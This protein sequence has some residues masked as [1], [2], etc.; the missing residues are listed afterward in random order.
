[1]INGILVI[2]HYLRSN[3]F[4]DLYN[5]FKTSA[6]NNNINLSVKTNREILLDI[7]SSTSLAEN[8]LYTTDTLSINDALL[9][10][11][12]S[13]KHIITEQ[14]SNDRD[15]IFNNNYN[16]KDNINN[17]ISF[18]LF[19]DKDVLL[20]R[21]LESKGY[22]VFN[23]SEA[24]RICDDK[25]LTHIELSNSNIPMPRTIVSPFTYDIQYNQH[26][27]G[28]LEDVANKLG[29]PMV[30]KAR[31]G[32]FGAQVHIANNQNE[33]QEVT[34]LYN[35]GN[36]IYQEYIK[37]SHGKDIRLQ[38]VGDKVVCAM[39][40]YSDSDFRANISNGG[41]MKEYIPSKEECDLAVKASMALG[42]DFAGVDLLFGDNDTR[43]VCE[44]N[45]NAHFR[46]IYDLTGVDVADCITKYILDIISKC[47]Q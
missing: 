1:M 8:S 25:A 7:E 20:A 41:H 26:H 29:F 3:K 45:S 17:N 42:L 36:V 6:Y 14:T 23:S 34:E 11:D 40:R 21:Y 9:T 39:Y 19:W 46:N 28:F 18:I 27:N 16:D 13:N 47:K 22:R 43:L 33:L 44:V 30:V 5:M 32:S 2:N 35:A 37:T 12:I 4:D 24:I 31:Q 10:H 15:N 38:V